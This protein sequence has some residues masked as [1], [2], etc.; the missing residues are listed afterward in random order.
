MWRAFLL[1]PFSFVGLAQDLASY[2]VQTVTVSNKFVEGPVWCAHDGYLL[3]S[4]I[5]ANKIHKIDA[6][7]PSVFREDSG[8]AHEN[9]PKGRPT[10]KHPQTGPSPI[11]A[12]PR[13]NRS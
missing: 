7:G 12:P 9:T 13:E 10:G 11:E 3:Y 6:K 5:P 8:G 1:L 2:Q 4:D